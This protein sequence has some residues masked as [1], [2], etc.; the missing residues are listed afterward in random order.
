MYNDCF[1]V[2][3]AYTLN[4]NAPEGGYPSGAASSLLSNLNW[5]QWA[6]WC[7]EL[8]TFEDPDVLTFTNDTFRVAA[9]AYLNYLADHMG[10]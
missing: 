5:R 4:P 9:M 6:P 10:L 3:F 8:L 2:N 1:S 7:P